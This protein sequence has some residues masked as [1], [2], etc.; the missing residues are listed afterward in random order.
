MARRHMFVAVVIV[1]VSSVATAGAAIA[2]HRDPDVDSGADVSANVF[3]HGLTT[4]HLPPTEKNVERVSRLQ[5]TNLPSGIADVG[6]LKG[7]AYLAAWAPNCPNAANPNR[8]GGV[9]V[10]DVRN[11][12]SPSQVGFLPAG[13]NEYPGEGIHLMSVDTSSFKGDLLVHNNEFCNTAASQPGTGGFSIWDVTNPLAPKKLAQGGDILPNIAGQPAGTF[14]D[15]HSVQGWTQPGKAFAVATDN[16]ENVTAPFKDVDIFDISNPAQPKL[17][18]EV[19]LED[20]PG[21]TPPHANGDTVFHHDTQ[22]KR[23]G[24]HDFLAVSYWDAGQVLLNVDDPSKPTFMTDSGFPSPDPETA[25]QV[26]EGNSHESYWSSNDKFLLSSDED[27][28]AFRTLFEITTGPNAGEYG[29]GEFG[30]T[31]PVDSEPGGIINGPAVFGG[32]GCFAAGPNAGPDAVADPQPP[33]ASAIPANAG[34]EKTVVFSRGGCFFSTKIAAGQ[35]LGYDAVIIGQSHGGTRGGLLPDAFFCGGQG[36]DYDEQIPAICI[37]HR[38]MHLLFND[39]PAYTD[40]NEGQDIPLGTIGDRYTASTEFDGWGY[41][42]LH[43]TTK[44]D[45]PIIGTYSVFEAMHESFATNF[46]TLSVHEI[47]TDPRPNVNTGYIAYYNAGFRVVDFDSSG[48]REVGRYIGEKGNDFWGIFPV[49]DETA[50]HGYASDQPYQKPLLLLSDRDY[51]L[52]ILRYTGSAGTCAKQEVTALGTSAADQW[53]GTSG[54]DVVKF[55]DGN[56]K[57]NGAKGK[58]RLC[59]DT[60]KDRLKGG[61]KRDVLVGGPGKDTCI[62]GP[63]RDKFRGCEKKKQ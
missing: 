58:D 8:R 25:F 48:I 14:H 3:H 4:G 55:L 31:P 6:Y 15:Y 62:G 21:V 11:P 47:K 27:F 50:G 13:P 45:L 36:H 52:Y 5:L 29:A 60:G 9:Y 51:G 10:V 53:K 26:A 49:G 63:G 28:S 61:P 12:A 33:P 20:W 42:N 40:P 23:I 56:D 43:D 17:I 54:K 35:D 2:S 39:T 18:A 46:G 37:G 1:L 34:E 24:G 7:Y 30:F 59:G 57:A 19:G 16:D 32:R 22:F 44:P 41:V 38:A